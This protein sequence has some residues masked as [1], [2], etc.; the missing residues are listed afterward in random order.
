MKSV[1]VRQSNLYIN[2]KKTLSR[3]L[4]L[5]G[6]LTSKTPIDTITSKVWQYSLWY[7]HFKGLVVFSLVR[8]IHKS[9]SFLNGTIPS[10][11]R[12]VFAMVLSLQT[13][14]W[15]TLT[16]TFTSKTQVLVQYN[17]FKDSGGILVGTLI[18]KNPVAF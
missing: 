13:L 17:H 4:F 1:F 2:V 12:V 5:V 14:S 3:K 9:G 8:A 10:K 16:A 7:H 18:S 15:R 6:N 11:T